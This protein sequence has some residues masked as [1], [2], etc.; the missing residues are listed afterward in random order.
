MPEQIKISVIFPVTPKRIYD[1]WLNGKKH[2]AMT[3]ASATSSNK[4]GGKFTAW[5]KYISG[6]NLELVPNKRILQAWRSTEFSK[7]HLDSYLLI[8]LEEV[9]NGTK[10]SIVHTE[11]PDGTGAAY[12]KGWKDFYFA[13]MKKYFVK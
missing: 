6:K 8:K 11:I 10:V 2:S 5:D 12:K 13:P 4:I 7:D 9:K 3:G 1:A